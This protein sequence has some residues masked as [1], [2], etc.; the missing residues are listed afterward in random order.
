MFSPESILSDIDINIMED[1]PEHIIDLPHFDFES[2]V[3][4]E[5]MESLTKD[6]AIGSNRAK[7]DRELRRQSRDLLRILSDI[8]HQVQNDLSIEV[9]KDKDDDDRPSDTH[10]C[11]DSELV[12]LRKANKT[13]EALIDMN[14]ELKKKRREAKALKKLHEMKERKKRKMTTASSFSSLSSEETHHSQE[15]QISHHSHTSQK[16]LCD[17]EPDNIQSS[18]SCLI[19]RSPRP[20]KHEQRYQP[21]RYPSQ[22]CM[23]PQSPLSPIHEQT[24]QPYHYQSSPQPMYFPQYPSYPQYHYPPFL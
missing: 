21:Y 15:T 10:R 8:L 18:Q 2:K 13:L 14:R 1:I 3:E 24:Y 12:T 11:R 20:S 16:T 23:I 9:V 6:F 7:K 17:H 4:N 19:L 5:F 22:S